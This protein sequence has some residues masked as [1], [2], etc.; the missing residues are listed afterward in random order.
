VLLL[1]FV[2]GVFWCVEIPVR[3]TVMAEAGGAE[4]ATLTM[5]LEMLTTH[6]T[7]L[8]GPALGGALIAGTGLGGVFALG[9]LLYL[10]GALL[11]ARVPR[12]PPAAAGRQSL[13]AALADGVRAVRRDPRLMALIVITLVFNLFGLPYLGLLPVFA[14]RRL[15]LGPLGTGLLATGEGVG[16][17][18]GTLAILARPRPA[19][20]GPVFGWGTAL[21]FA[22]VTAL[23]LTPAVAA[24][25]P[26]LLVAG[27]GMAGFS[28]MQA[29]LPLAVLPPGMRVRVAGVVMVAIGSAPL[30]F[31][32]AGTLGDRL[33]G[34]PGITALGAVGLLATAAVLW[35]WPA[36]ARPARA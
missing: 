26:V 3:R 5:G 13:A 18:V 10:S 24:A 20:F 22:A 17:L 11:I 23:G 21:F 28:I 12:V 9:V 16:A 8:L 29:T 27:L 33:G 31:L 15:E 32:L 35:R 7:R 30:G 6:L 2:A 19:W 1:A 36:M 14:A 34:G 25:Y 4:R